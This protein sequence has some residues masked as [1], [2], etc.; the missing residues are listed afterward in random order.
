MGYGYHGAMDTKSR[1]VTFDGAPEPGVINFGVG[2]PSEDLLPVGLIR[3][4]TAD[5]LAHA[6]PLELNYGE[7]Q[8]DAGFRAALAGFLSPEYAYPVTAESLFVTAGNSQAL[9][10][11]CGHFARQGDT[12]FI[13][14]PSYFLAH[15]IF[16][17]HGLHAVGIPVD[18]DGL[19]IDILKEKLANHRPAL[20]YTIPSFH[21]PGGQTLSEER[22][23]ELARLSH[24]HDFLVVADEVYQLLH[25]FGQPPPAMGT[26]TGSGNI[27]SLGSFSKIMAPGLR[28]GWIQTSPNLMERMLDTGVI[29][30]GGSFNHF[31]SHVMR[32]AIELGLQQSLLD[33]L[34][35]TY[36]QRVETMDRS[37]HKHLG[38]LAT[39]RRPGGGYFFWLEFNQE[40]DCGKLKAHAGEFKT[41]FQQGE[42]FSCNSG[43][44]NCLRLSF[45]HY[46]NEDIEE[47]ISRLGALLNSYSK[48]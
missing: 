40:V 7:R 41:G 21:N 16:A 17:D 44:K 46:G 37:L 12:V 35:S 24:E 38:G 6:H 42:V 32:H 27:L 15:Q 25:Y 36:R 4:A 14:E 13:E 20:L 18:N 28:L 31:T 5:F 22:R 8:G 33:T 43:L 10:F 2:Q 11:I 29:N 48:L 3:D 34:R 26:M 30:S 1:T 9:D 39:W 23:H 47:G 19:M 45:A